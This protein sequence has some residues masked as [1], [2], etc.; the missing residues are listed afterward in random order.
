MRELQSADLYAEE[1]EDYSDHRDQLI[2]WETFESEVSEYGEM[3]EL[4]TQ[5][6]AFVDNLKQVLTETAHQIDS[7]Y[8]DNEYLDMTSDGLIIRKHTN[9]NKPD[10]LASIDQQIT[11]QLPAT[12]IL[13][14]LVNAEGWLDLHRQFGPLLG[15]ETKMDDPRKRFITTLFC[16]GCNLRLL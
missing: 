16:Y 1:S 6:K 7:Q 15:F 11:D 12:N 10:A 14:L 9:G 5:P 13:D 8:P 2:D 3:I 4:L